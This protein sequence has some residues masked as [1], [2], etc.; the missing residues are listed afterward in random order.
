M[1]VDDIMRE[2]G[3]PYRRSRFTSKPLP[4]TYA[5]YTDDITSEGADNIGC[6]TPKIMTHQ[7][8][9]E[10]Y[11]ST[12]DDEAEAKI[13]AALD[14]RGFD[15]QKQD[16]YWLQSEQRYQTVYEFYYTI[17]KRRISS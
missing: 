16:R 17:K 1:V 8:S 6:H 12:P 9:V 4:P 3:I 7:I 5:V 13:E 14:A 2:A 11:E 10:V 15:W